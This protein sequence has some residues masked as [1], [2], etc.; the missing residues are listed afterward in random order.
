MPFAKAAMLHLQMLHRL[1]SH[2]AET[3]AS[4]TTHGHALLTETHVAHARQR[5]TGGRCAA[6]QMVVHAHQRWDVNQM[7]ISNPA[8]HAMATNHEVDLSVQTTP[9]ITE[10]PL[11]Q[12][13]QVYHAITI[14][15]VDMI[16]SG[17]AKAFA[18]LLVFHI[19]PPVSGPL[20]VKVDTESGGNTL[21]LRTFRQMFH[22]TPIH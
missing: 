10:D 21:P 9:I 11:E 2:C 19:K 14:S 22:G 3:L 6:R 18:E 1:V 16:N 4:N 7:K 17:S 8:D 13:H 15:N 12:C 5:G 20:H